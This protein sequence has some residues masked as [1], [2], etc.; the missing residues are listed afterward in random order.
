MMANE[1]AMRE[2]FAQFEPERSAQRMARRSFEVNSLA[3]RKQQIFSG[4]A[5]IQAWGQLAQRE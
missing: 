4:H 2:R 1:D 3:S 5:A